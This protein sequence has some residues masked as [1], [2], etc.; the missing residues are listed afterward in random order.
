M[1][2]RTDREVIYLIG[3]DAYEKIV[4]ECRRVTYFNRLP[5]IIYL[6]VVDALECLKWQIH[7]DTAENKWRSRFNA[8]REEWSEWRNF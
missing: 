7:V 2:T 4:G 8:Y 6:E 3:R 5:G 1:K